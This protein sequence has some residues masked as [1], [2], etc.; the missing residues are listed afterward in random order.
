MG[1]RDEAKVRKTGVI[2]MRNLRLRRKYLKGAVA[3]GL[4]KGNGKEK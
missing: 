4:R 2:D 1:E 3:R